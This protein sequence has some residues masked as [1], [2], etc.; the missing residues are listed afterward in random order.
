[1]P[2]TRKLTDLL[3][4]DPLGLIGSGSLLITCAAVAVDGLAAAIRSAGVAVAVIGE[5][6]A[7]GEGIEALCG[8]RSVPWPCFE[9][10]E[11]TRLF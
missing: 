7:A 10:D 6:L 3:G 11:I 2:E 8:G 5:V 4:L 1:L 9:V